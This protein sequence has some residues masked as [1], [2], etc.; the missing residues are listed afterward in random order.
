MV[1]ACLDITERILAGE[2]AVDDPLL[3]AQMALVA[4]RPVGQDGAFRFSRQ[5][6]GGPIDA[7]MAMTLAVHAIA[8]IGSGA[9]IG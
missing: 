4:K 6:S 7:V 2:L 9:L 3:D 8:A 5:A 1:S